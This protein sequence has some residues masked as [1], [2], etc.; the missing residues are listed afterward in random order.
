MGPVKKQPVK[1]NPGVKEEEEKREKE[2]L[3]DKVRELEEEVGK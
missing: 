1:T 3:E 2:L